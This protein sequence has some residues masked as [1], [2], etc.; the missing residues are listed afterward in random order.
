[1]AVYIIAYDLVRAS[2]NDYKNVHEKIES[3]SDDWAHIQLSTFLVRSEL[4]A[5]QFRDRLRPVFKE[6]EKLIVAEL[7]GS[8]AGLHRFS[9]QVSG[10]LE[11]N[12]F[13]TV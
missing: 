11:R 2:E 5:L 7:G 1:M 12:G 4:T 6:D 3:I 9:K 8:V 10:W 13:P